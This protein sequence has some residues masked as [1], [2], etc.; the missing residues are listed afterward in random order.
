LNIYYIYSFYIP[1]FLY[2]YIYLNKYFRIFWYF[3]WVFNIRKFSNFLYYIFIYFIYLLFEK[4]ILEKIEFTR[5][6]VNNIC[7]PEKL[8]CEVSENLDNLKQYTKNMRNDEKTQNLSAPQIPFNKYNRRIVEHAYFKS[9]PLSTKEMV[10]DLYSSNSLWMTLSIN[11]SPCEALHYETFS[12]WT[13][14]ISIWNIIRMKPFSH[15]RKF[16]F[17]FS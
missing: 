8:K 10:E 4:N 14:L 9:S 17:I 3:G 6:V 5:N 13:T 1:F 7:S 15:K 16:V 11:N 12:V 2:I